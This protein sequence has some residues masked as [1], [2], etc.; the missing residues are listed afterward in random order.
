MNIAGV[1]AFLLRLVARLP[2]AGAVVWCQSPFETR[3]YGRL[4]A[5]GLA[6]MALGPERL[7]A[8][9]LSHPREMGFVLEAALAM[10]PV[11]AVVGEGAPLEF[12]QTRRLS[13]ISAR[14]GVPC[15]YLNTECEVEASAARTRWRVNPVPA[16]GDPADE[17]M[18]GAPAWGVALTRARGGRPGFWEL[19]WH[20]ATH[21]FRALSRLGDRSPASARNHAATHGDEAAG[22]RRRTG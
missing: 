9:S 11:A 18:P 5:P 13:L 2:R 22:Q 20:D 12:T 16:A 15:I 14:S 19:T 1:S 6:G 3:E 21:S 4:Y 8:V 17:R 7:V 10:A